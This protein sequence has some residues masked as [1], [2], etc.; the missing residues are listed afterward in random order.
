MNMCIKN[1]A[2]GGEK[3]GSS[4][5][6]MIPIITPLLLTM[7]TKACGFSWLPFPSAVA[8]FLRSNNAG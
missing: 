8:P 7:L 4:H 6:K 2:R 1:K 5:Q 3:K